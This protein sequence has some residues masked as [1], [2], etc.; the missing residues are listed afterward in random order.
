MFTMTSLL[1]LITA[2]QGASYFVT[3]TFRPIRDRVCDD[4]KQAGGACI[5]HQSTILR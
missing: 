5:I 4:K 3:G 1:L 2:N